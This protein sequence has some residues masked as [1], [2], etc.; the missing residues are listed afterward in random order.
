MLARSGT[1]VSVTDAQ[2]RALFDRSDV[3][4]EGGARD[5][6]DGRVWYGSTSLI[7]P[8]TDEDAPILATLAAYDMHVRLRAVR[9]ARTEAALRAPGRLGRVACEIRVMRAARG[10]R[11]DVDVQAPLIER[12]ATVR[13]AR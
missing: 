3:I 13:P 6:R 2:W 8:T 1:Y 4:S 11:I 10:V 5:E 9:T 7:L 12:R